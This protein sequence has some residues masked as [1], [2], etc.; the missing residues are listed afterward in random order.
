MENC[1]ALTPYCAGADNRSSGQ[2]GELP[3]PSRMKSFCTVY[4]VAFRY[5]QSLL[6]THLMSQPTIAFL[7]G[8][9]PESCED[10]QLWFQMRLSDS[11]HYH[12]HN[13]HFRI[14]S[15]LQPTLLSFAK[16]VT[17]AS[18]LA[19]KFSQ[20]HMKVLPVGGT[21]VAII[22]AYVHHIRRR[23]SRDQLLRIY[24]LLFL[25]SKL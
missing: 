3:E 7:N 11:H 10:A 6:E 2:S 1:S 20:R 4:R 12:R 13:A 17:L 9:I 8:F 21:K 24:T 19:S 14:L 16:F 23:L 25:L 15:R 18:L 22:F 5:P